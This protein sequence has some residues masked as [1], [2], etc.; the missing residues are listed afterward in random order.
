LLAGFNSVSNAVL[1]PSSLNIT[2]PAQAPSAAYSGT[3]I[4]KNTIK[5]SI[6]YQFEIKVNALPALVL[7]DMPSVCKGTLNADISFTGLSGEP[8]S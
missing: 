8:N 4:V 6:S 7:G 5:S 2:I 1:T 3:I